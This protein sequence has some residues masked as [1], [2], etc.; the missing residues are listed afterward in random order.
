MD[1]ARQLAQQLDGYGM[2]TKR[3]RVL[4]SLGLVISTFRV[5]AGSD[6]QQITRDVR[7][8]YPRM[9]VDMNHRYSLLGNNRSS[10][11][12][13]SLVHWQGNGRGC[14]RG[15]RIG[16]IDTGI[17]KNHPA[18]QA[19][20]IV[21]HS[22]LSQGIQRA[23][24][25][26]GTA[27]ASL[28]VGD[29]RKPD[30]TGL[31]PGAKLFSVAAFRQRDKYNTDTT[32]EWIVSA[33]DWL[34]SQQVQAINMSFGGPRNLLVDLAIQRSI[35]AGITV[36][37]AAGNNGP[38][39]AP[40]YP[41][42]QPGVIAVTAVDS[43]LHLYAKASHGAYIDFAAPG[44]DVWTADGRN[45]GHFVSGTSYSTPFVTAGMVS[46]AQKSGPRKA[47]ED[48]QKAAR[49]LGTPGKDEA[50]GWGLLQLA[51]VCQ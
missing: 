9:W 43:A 35:Q 13:K 30:F 7:Q 2:S 10:R 50:Y 29:A 32:A 4:K 5:P 24:T 14:G 49:D 18:L 11:G 1:A 28:L 25:D 46:L 19:Q 36:I 3:R 20:P 23:K 39:S 45:G 48:L 8:A 40:V 6:M 12:A 41:A 22:V 16:L 31:L 17:N 38:E 21:E 27:I 51:Q 47:Y 44:V 42:A 15:L 26:H 33:I 34:L 37:A